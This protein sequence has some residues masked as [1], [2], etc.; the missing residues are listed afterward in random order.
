MM[1]RTLAALAALA[2]VS[3]LAWAGPPTFRGLSNPAGP[4]QFGDAHAVSANGA[5]VVGGGHNITLGAEAV[6]WTATGGT[7]GIGDLPGGTFSS[8]ANAISPDGS[9]IV[10][11]GHSA[12]GYEAFRWTAGGGIQGL[13]DFAGGMFYS[14]AF[15]VG[16]T[17]AVGRG[18]SAAG[19]QACRWSDGSIIPLPA[20]PTGGYPMSARAVSANGGVI[21]G[22]DTPW[23]WTQAGGLQIL[24]S[25]PGGAGGYAEGVSDNGTFIVGGEP[26][27]SGQWEAFLWSAAGGIRGLGDLSGG[28]FDSEARDV[29]DVGVVV[30]YGNL[31]A[32][33]SDR[34]AMIWD[35]VH[36]MRN[37]RE[38]L[39]TEYGLA[40]SLAGWTLTEANG[41]TPIGLTIVGTGINPQGQQEAWMAQL[42][43]PA[44]LS[45][46][47]LG[48][49]AIIRRRRS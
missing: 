22:G 19:W 46:L 13:G 39:A 2:I 8:W 49:A 12:N 21:V 35:E 24:P 7:Q 43:E 17:G 30:G 34:V 4:I 3:S 14:E 23:R 32:D 16:V 15:D 10:G 44:T 25:L 47:A 45:L 9:T 31:T 1:T 28:V 42:P 29:S 38:V 41:I 26:S 6:R 33:V 20:Y 18:N 27:A 48:A 5:V 11:C 40:A 37:L 36:G